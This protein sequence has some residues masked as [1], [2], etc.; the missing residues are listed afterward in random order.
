MKI[1]EQLDY[2]QCECYE[3]YG[4][5]ETVSH[6]AL[7][8]VN[9]SEKQPYFETLPGVAIRTDARG[10]LI[11]SADYL[12]QPVVTNDVV[13]I[14]DS[15]KFLW[16]G[17]WDSVINSGGVKVIPEK[18]EK[19]LEVIFNEHRFH[20]RFFI[21]AWP[22]E[23]LGEKVVLVLEGV[24]FSSEILEQ[25]LAAL[26]SAVSPYEFP[27]AVYSIPEFIMTDTQKIQRPQ[28]LA[29]VTPLLS[30]I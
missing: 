19:A 7:R 13:E 3:T 12:L 29:A 8:L 21:A 5:T 1:R 14:I 2:Y 22:D 10:C 24:Q 30:S 9:T 28:T 23:K 16:L 4:M 26:K 11:V 6:V 27:K 25:S 18:I 17:R 20:H 15:G